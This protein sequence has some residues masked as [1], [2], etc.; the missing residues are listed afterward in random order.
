MLLA[1]STF[2]LVS[3]A[4]A[5]PPQQRLFYNPYPSSPG[6]GYSPV[7]DDFLYQWHRSG[8]LYEVGLLLLWPWITFLALMIFQISMRR[9]GIRRMHVLRTV[10]YSGDFVFWAGLAATLAA[11]MLL[12]TQVLFKNNPVEIPIWLYNWVF[13]ACW[14]VMAYRLMVAYRRYLRFDHP[15]A[16]VIASQIVA[17]LLILTMFFQVLF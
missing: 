10:L 14:V 8:A 16:T 6:S 17:A 13:M 4:I 11:G 9:A 3:D 5:N 7:F 12:G 15:L 1:G 2:P